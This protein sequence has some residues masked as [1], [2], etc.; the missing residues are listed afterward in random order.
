MTLLNNAKVRK[1]I[2]DKAEQLRSAWAARGLRVS[3][4]T[5]EYLDNEVRIAV[6]KLLTRHPSVGRTIYPPHR[7]PKGTGTT[8]DVA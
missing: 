1:H 6:D 4:E 2:L 8:D 7:I 3:G 5:L